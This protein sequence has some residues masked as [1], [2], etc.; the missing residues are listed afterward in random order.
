MTSIAELETS[1]DV[2]IVATNSD[3][4]RITIE[5]LLGRCSVPYLVLEKALFQRLKDYD[6]VAE[7][8]ACKGIKA[9]VNCPR[10][11]LSF[12]ADVKKDFDT[13]M[14]ISFQVSGNW[15]MGCNAIHMIDLFHFISSAQCFFNIL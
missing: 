13:A 7:L 6:E 3:I 9:W 4:R 10:R 12:Y 11:M 8:L 5:T 2:A 14:P 1:I 15:A